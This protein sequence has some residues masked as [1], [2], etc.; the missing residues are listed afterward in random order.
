VARQGVG[1]SWPRGVAPHVGCQHLR[2]LSATPPE[3]DRQVTWPVRS[4]LCE[5]G[6]G[7]R[8]TVAVSTSRKN[9]KFRGVPMRYISGHNARGED[10]YGW[11]GGRRFRNSGR[12]VTVL[13]PH[14]PRADGS[15]YVP[16]HWLIA[17]AAH[18][19]P[20]PERAVIHHYAYP[21]PRALVVCE[22]QS[23]HVLIERRTRAFRESGHADWL[24]CW[25]CRRWDNPVSLFVGP[26]RPSDGGRLVYHAACRQEYSR[27]HPSPKRRLP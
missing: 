3:A 14:H 22:N 19:G 12:Y 8:T 25:I 27:T 13:Q 4:G 24:W 6:C 20:L 10:H 2:G 7:E 17:E 1:V 5:C 9:G 23:Y 18:G 26:V 16:E 15:G 21:D 11:K